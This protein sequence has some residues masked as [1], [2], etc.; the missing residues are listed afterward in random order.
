M[1]N[2]HLIQWRGTIVALYGVGGMYK[3]CSCSTAS[4][5][6]PQKPQAEIDA[7]HCQGKMLWTDWPHPKGSL[8]ALGPGWVCTTHQHLSESTALPILENGAHGDNQPAGNVQGMSQLWAAETLSQGVP[9][10]GEQLSR[11]V[12]QQVMMGPLGASRNASWN[13]RD[14]L[15]PGLTPGI[16]ACKINDP[17]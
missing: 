16:E 2:S 17:A 5:A 7:S 3:V 9:L 8:G 13:S 10:P 12:R 11:A 1:D 14:L 4:P 15:N 6:Q